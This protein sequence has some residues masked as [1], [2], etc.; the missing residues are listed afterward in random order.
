MHITLRPGEKLYL[1]GAV[2]RADR[3]VS[4]ELMNDASF[5]L[6]A[7]VMHVDK[8]T[9]PLRQLYFVVQTMLMS[10][11]D[12]LAAR[13]MFKDSL[14]RMHGVYEA[15]PVLDALSEI[16]TF[17]EAARFFEALKALRGLFAVDDAL[18]S[19]QAGPLAL[20]S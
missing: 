6:E 5:L 2:L 4:I 15:R 12:T 1:N 7:H 17:V 19:A 10:P 3:K 9:T 16:A 13:T 14:R 20:A 8:A 11:G 18:M